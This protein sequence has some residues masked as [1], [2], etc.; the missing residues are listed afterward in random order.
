MRHAPDCQCA[1]AHKTVGGRARPTRFDGQTSNS[2]TK[3]DGRAGKRRI[4][5][6]ELMLIVRFDDDGI[7][8]IVGER[9]DFD[10]RVE[11]P[12][13]AGLAQIVVRR[14]KF[15]IVG[16]VA[17]PVFF[18]F[19]ERVVHFLRPNNVEFVHRFEHKTAAPELQ[20]R[21]IIFKL[22]NLFID[23]SIIF[24][25]RTALLFL[26]ILFSQTLFAQ[27]P[28][29]RPAR[30]S[31]LA[32]KNNVGEAESLTRAIA[33]ADA[34]ERLAALRKFV[35]DFPRSAE[36]NRAQELI[37]SARAALGDAKL[38][39][40]DT[41]GGI[42]QFKTAISESP[43]PASDKLFTEILMRIPNSLFARGQTAAA[44]DA[45]RLIE[46]KA[47]GNAKQT[48]AVAGFY[49][50]LENAAEAKRLAE[51][52][53][54]LDAALPA[55]Y[56]TLGLA[57]RLDFQLEDSVNAYQ[58]ALELA[59]DSAISKRSLAE[60]KRAVG[61]PA[62]A[63]ALYREI[64][65]QN[66]A[67]AAAQTGLIL[68]LFDAD[69]KA[70]AESEMQSSLDANP[71]NLSLLVGAAYWYAARK[72]GA[73]AVELAEKAVALEPRYTWARIALARGL[74][75]QN[76]PLD[77]E[78]ELL[79][80]QNYG[81]F[82]TLEYELAAVR[83]QSGFF[84]E[85]AE[86][87]AKD[88]TIRNDLIEAKLGGRVPSAAANFIE[89]L[90]LERRAS[91]LEP[92]T[93]DDAA[94]ADRLKSLLDL[95]QQLE[96]APNDVAVVAK[97]DEFVKGDDK[98][99]LHR[100]I[101]A[102]DSL[103]NKK[104]NLPKI[105]ELSKAAVG[106]V[107]AG[108]SVENPAAAVLADE[109]YASRR[110]A[111]TQG[112]IIIVP[113]VSRQ[114]LSNIV[115]GRIENLAGWTLFQENKSA[116]AVVRLKRAVSIFPENS[117]YWRDAEWRLGTALESDDK[118]KDALAAYVK[119]YSGGEPSAVKYGIIQSAYQRV[120]GTTD[121]L[122]AQIGAK[123]DT[124]AFDAFAQNTLP[125]NTP[126]P[127]ETAPAPPEKTETVTPA[128]VTP[129]PVAPVKTEIIAPPMV[130]AEPIKV[131]PVAPPVIAKVVEPV[132]KVV[133]E[134]PPPIVENAPLPAPANLKPVDVDETVAAP[135]VENT[136]TETAPPIAAEPIKIAAPVNAPP[137]IAPTLQ[138]VTEDAAPPAPKATENG[139]KPL[140]EPVIITVPKTQ[141]KS[142][143]GQER[144]SGGQNA[145]R[146]P[147]VVVED[148]S[149]ANAPCQITVNQE[150]ASVV[151]D[152][153][154][155]ALIVELVGDGDLRQIKAASS[156]PANVEIAFDSAIV[157]ETKRALFILKSI[158][159]RR[160]DYAVTFET[161]CARKEIAVN[162]R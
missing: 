34:A 99:K 91:I 16:N 59:P 127:V 73:K 151:S 27:R 106:T 154:N 13:D 23:L 148:R 1:A 44:V 72:D 71:N 40:G 114:I 66:S 53:L 153:G 31:N 145:G 92:L 7:A 134:E 113:D 146:R 157:G 29:P 142:A 4:A 97:V 49:L 57:N 150:F 156:S 143:D 5:D 129:A 128:P 155:L 110:T 33:I 76:R 20:F 80:A 26:L 118:L 79:A 136:P 144:K 103:L 94:N 102:A 64:L 112:K 21:V 109:L 126:N 158:S 55:A 123:P 58:K 25:K 78:K 137:T 56:Q 35:A 24:M 18:G 43:S 50:S 98:M 46:A 68:A 11:Q 42:A 28:R 108:L 15:E 65:A 84:R 101:F 69:D 36:K 120:N 105:L 9:R 90:S 61:K 74:M 131:A 52:S 100:Q 37:V 86:G 132:T 139:V 41:D 62:E 75:A 82:P 83:A 160:G 38:Q 122:E 115:R 3:V 32:A 116:E 140:F 141:V 104:S 88:F 51:K 85:A 135:P 77:A 159:P 63:V 125:V 70:E 152:G 48:L 17:A 149:A 95:H 14:A 22:S 45:A 39:A 161:P 2:Q 60:M 12:F 133:V 147:R 130:A 89:L 47:D 138:V 30:T 117:A 54:A 8:V 111:L 81:N 93:A 162:V 19:G 67:D 121:G 119:S 96:S 124:S 107:E 87:L 10:E 6:F